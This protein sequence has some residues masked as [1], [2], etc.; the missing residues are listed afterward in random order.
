MAPSPSAPPSRPRSSPRRSAAATWASPLAALSPAAVATAI[1][2]WGDSGQ[3]GTYLPELTGDD[4]P[5][6]A[7]AIQEPRALFDPFELKTTATRT[8]DGFKLDGEK[9]LVARGAD[10]ELFVVAR[11]STT[12]PRSSSSRPKTKG[13]LVEPQPAMGLRAAATANLKLDGVRLPAEA[14]LGEGDPDVYADCI[15][16]GPHRLVGAG[17][18]HRAGGR[19]LRHPLR[20]RADRLRR[21]DLSP[22]GGRLQGRR[23]RHRARGHAPGDASRGQ[24]RRPG[25]RLRPRVQRSPAASSPRRACRSARTAFSS[26]AATATSRNTRSS[27]GTATCEQPAWSKEVYLV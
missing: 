20:E 26:W 3:Q 4:V 12:A 2:L 8:G 11:R 9:S 6:A 13:V 22:P 17:G 10:S 18:R 25:S 15:R 21:A 1:G 5:A 19:R 24:P 27:A 7:L 23:H 14:L 16:L